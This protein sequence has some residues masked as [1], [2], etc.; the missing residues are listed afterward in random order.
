MVH[1]L[2]EFT[3]QLVVN[4]VEQNKLNPNEL[5]KQIVNA[6]VIEYRNSQENQGVDVSQFSD[7]EIIEI[8]Y[9]QSLK[10]ISFNEN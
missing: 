2:S 3:S 4:F 5:N 1:L 10:S 8:I 9:Q 7:D 6:F